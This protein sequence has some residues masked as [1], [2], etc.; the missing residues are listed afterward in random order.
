M[1]LD[2]LLRKAIGKMNRELEI[3]A[4]MRKVRETDK[5]CKSY[6]KTELFHGLKKKYK[7]NYLN[8]LNVSLETVKSIEEE[9]QDP[10]PPAPVP[11][12][13][14][15][16][17]S[18]FEGPDGYIRPKIFVDPFE[19][20][21]KTM[22]QITKTVW[23][24]IKQDEEIINKVETDLLREERANR[25]KYGKGMIM[26][27]KSVKKPITEKSHRNTEVISPLNLTGYSQLPSAMDDSMIR[28]KSKNALRKNVL[29]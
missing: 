1:A 17:K 28:K 16:L 9:Y 5:L 18:Y 20:D 11:Y 23:K 4:L 22:G 21:K 27:E 15:K 25:Y 7:N 12:Q 24:K 6:E 2:R 13:R 29:K 10:L 14:K 26:S 3:S 19:I 8:V